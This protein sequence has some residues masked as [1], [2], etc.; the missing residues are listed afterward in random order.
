M[1]NKVSH[2]CILFPLLIWLKVALHHSHIEAGSGTLFLHQLPTQRFDCS[3]NSELYF[4]SV[5]EWL[6]RALRW[7]GSLRNVM[8]FL[9]NINISL[10]NI[11]RRGSLKP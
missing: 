7:N 1:N 6:G 10:F 11:L 5:S 4:Y 9:A 3:L 2:K 8:P